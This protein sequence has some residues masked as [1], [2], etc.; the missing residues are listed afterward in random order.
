MIPN[1]LIRRVAFQHCKLHFLFPTRPLYSGST[2]VTPV[3]DPSLLDCS[4]AAA[5]DVDD[6]A[7]IPNFV[8]GEEE[9]QLMVDIR[10]TLRGKKY[11]YDHWDGVSIWLYK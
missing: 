6:F 9:E 7:V 11:L 2:L 4:R 3:A 10:R 5:Q 1:V 8:S